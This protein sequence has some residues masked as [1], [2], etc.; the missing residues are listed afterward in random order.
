[1]IR[2]KVETRSEIRHV[3]VFFNKYPIAHLTEM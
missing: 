1:M 3:D 2:C